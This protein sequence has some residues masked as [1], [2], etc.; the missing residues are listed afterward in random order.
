M[1]LR[2]GY[3]CEPDVESIDKRLVG[4]HARSMKKV[5]VPLTILLLSACGNNQLAGS[6]PAPIEPEHVSSEGTTPTTPTTVSPT[7]TV[8][9]AEPADPRLVGPRQAFKVLLPDGFK[10]R[11]NGLTQGGGD[12]FPGHTLDTATFIDI[13][14]HQMVTISLER[15]VDA[16]VVAKPTDP[17]TESL[18]GIRSE[19]T[20]MLW[21]DPTSKNLAAWWTP[22][23]SSVVWVYGDG[24]SR[25]QLTDVVKSIEVAS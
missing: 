4:A 13:A 21:T 9:G 17:A 2:I 6:D 16:Q 20:V 11:G 10:Q 8:A 5:W 23:P 19:A 24:M 12:S 1:M 7:T 15:G 18:A 14:M 25:E 22:S 3:M